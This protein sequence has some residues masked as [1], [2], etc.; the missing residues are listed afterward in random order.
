LLWQTRSCS[1]GRLGK[2]LVSLP[3][4]GVRPHLSLLLAGPLPTG[5]APTS[6]PPPPPVRGLT[7]NAVSSEKGQPPTQPLPAGPL[8][9]GSAALHAA[10]PRRPATYG[11]SPHLSFLRKGSD[12]ARRPPP[13]PGPRAAPGRPEGRGGAAPL[14]GGGGGG[15]AP[16]RGGLRLGSDPFRGN[17]RLGSAP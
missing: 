1:Q 13:P 16:F 12:P 14:G 17:P 4:C 2:H 10:P 15:I 9:T 11:V 7:L 8:P 6:A 3:D 5:S